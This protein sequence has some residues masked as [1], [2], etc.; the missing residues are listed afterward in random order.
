MHQTKLFFL[1]LIV[2]WIFIAFIII[3]CIGLHFVPES[4]Q[5]LMSQGFVKDAEETLKSFRH[6]NYDVSKE[7][8]TL[9]AAS[10]A[11]IDPHTNTRCAYLNFY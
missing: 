2:A 8:E 4:P 1:L 6:T 11:S 3:Q 7:L 5:W 9:K 10:K